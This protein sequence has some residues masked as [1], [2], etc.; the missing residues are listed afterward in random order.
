MY[1][2][3]QT[4]TYIYI[5]HTGLGLVTPFFVKQKS[6]DSWGSENKRNI[7]DENSSDYF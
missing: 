7:S 2:H 6:K 3:S 5:V 1:I 4:H